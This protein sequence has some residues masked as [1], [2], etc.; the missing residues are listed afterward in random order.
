MSSA[1]DWLPFDKL[2][3]VEAPPMLY[4]PTAPIFARVIT[5]ERLT[6]TDYSEDVRHIILDLKGTN[7]V[8]GEGQSVGVIAPGVGTN[9]KP[10][11]V[12]LYSIAS[13]GIGDDGYPNTVS[14]CVKRVEYQH[15]E[16]DFQGICSNFLCD[17]NPGDITAITGPAGKNFT[18][19]SNNDAD[20]LF[21]ATGTGIAPFRSF[22]MELNSR[23]NRYQGKIHL[24]FGSR[25]LIDH[26][27][28]NELNND[29]HKF[30]SNLDLTL[31]S[32]LSRQNPN[33]RVYVYDLLK[34]RAA[35]IEPILDRKNFSVYVCGIKGMEKGIESFLRNYVEQKIGAEID[36]GEWATIKDKLKK[37]GRWA[38]EVY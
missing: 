29:L 35:D 21:F 37:A 11:R 12:R 13:P 36:G 8:Y 38:Q 15:E 5:N 31:H 33:E 2:D 34:K 28:A 20:L 3:S 24:F 10:H 18:L 19:P 32:A 6:P 4:K 26:I 1:E 14:L 25:L 23:P 16:E 30:S 7:Y 17:L 9:G 22:L 27:Y